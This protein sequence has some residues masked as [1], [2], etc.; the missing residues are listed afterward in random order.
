MLA[1]SPVCVPNVPWLSV[2]TGDSLRRSMPRVGA[3]LF[4]HADN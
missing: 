3:Q 1:A 4:A 2:A